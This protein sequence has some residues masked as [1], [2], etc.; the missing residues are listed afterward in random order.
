MLYDQMMKN[1]RPRY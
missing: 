1:W